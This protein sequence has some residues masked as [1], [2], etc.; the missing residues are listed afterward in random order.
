MLGCL[1]LGNFFVFLLKISS[2][3]TFSIQ[4]PTTADLSEF[5]ARVIIAGGLYQRGKLSL[6]Q[7]AEVAGLSKRTFIEIMGKYGFSVF[8]ESMED[9]RHDLENAS[10]ITC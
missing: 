1:R 3:S 10:R 5:D 7:A 9:F 4:I 8:S 2:M 6:G